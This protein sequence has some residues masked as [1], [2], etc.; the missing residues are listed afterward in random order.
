MGAWMEWMDGWMDR[1]PHEWMDE[2]MDE[3]NIYSDNYKIDGGSTDGTIDAATE[4]GFKV[5]Q[6]RGKGLGDAYRHVVEIASSN[7]ILF[8]T[9]EKSL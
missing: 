7:N 1:Q 4:L 8:F 2:G 6:Q 9:G 3:D 5:I